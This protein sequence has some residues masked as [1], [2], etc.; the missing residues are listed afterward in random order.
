[1]RSVSAL[2]SL[3]DFAAMARRNLPG[4]WGLP[5]TV[6]LPHRQ[7]PYLA[8]ALPKLRHPVSGWQN[9]YGQQHHLYRRL[10][11]LF[12]HPSFSQ[13]IYPAGSFH[14]PA[15]RQRPLY[16]CSTQYNSAA[17]WSAL[18][19]TFTLRSCCPIIIPA[20]VQQANKTP[21][22]VIRRAPSPV[23]SI[24]DAP[25][26]LTIRQLNASVLSG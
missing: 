26:L 25:R 7:Q 5:L 2:E 3:F 24:S 23:L 1:M 17:G 18:S 19:S 10:P 8:T 22:L 13:N 9:S 16:P 20:P 12:P 11:I 15:E 14:G 6:Y 4:S 21:A